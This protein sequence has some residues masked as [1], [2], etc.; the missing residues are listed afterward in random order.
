MLTNTKKPVS[1][2][3]NYKFVTDTSSVNVEKEGWNY[4]E[5]KVFNETQHT[6]PYSH[7]KRNNQPMTKKMVDLEV[8]DLL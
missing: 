3:N 2:L 8:V 5:A 4:T 7:Q 1:V 6:T